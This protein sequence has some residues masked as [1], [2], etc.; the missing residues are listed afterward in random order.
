MAHDEWWPVRQVS[1][2]LRERYLAE[3]WWTDETLGALVDRSLRAAPAS[4]VNIWSESRPWHGTYADIRSDALRMVATLA[5]AGCAP[6]DV[7]AFQMP[8]W[9]EAVIAFYGLAM[10]GY[11]LVP[12]VHIYGHKEVRFILAQTGA[13]A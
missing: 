6:G 7:V 12:I 4:T 10:G 8:N 5:E 11:V 1:P 9:R 13:R 2:A 3:G